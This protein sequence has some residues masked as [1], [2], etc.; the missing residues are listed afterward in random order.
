MRASRDHAIR[1]D[2]RGQLVRA[3]ERLLQERA[4]SA[5]S[6]RDITGAANV[7]NPTLYYHFG[8]KEAFYATLL[9]ERLLELTKSI[10]GVARES[11]PDAATYLIDLARTFSDCVL[12][13]SA[14]NVVLRELVGQGEAAATSSVL[15]AEREVRLGFEEGLNAGIAAGEFRPD[16]D[17]RVTAIGIVGMLSLF[18]VRRMAGADDSDAVAVDWLARIIIP[19]IRHG[20]GPNAQQAGQGSP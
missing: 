12:T 15:R 9:E 5:I 4:L 1:E 18:A 3:F 6:V 2:A 19:G 7:S 8:T 10:S 11:S 17:V 14:P 20:A 13:F 16:L